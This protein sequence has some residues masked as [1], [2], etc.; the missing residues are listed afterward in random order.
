MGQSWNGATLGFIH[1]YIYYSNRI[2]WIFHYK[3]CILGH[4]H[5][6]KSPHAVLLSHGCPKDLGSAHRDS[7]PDRCWWRIILNGPSQMDADISRVRCYQWYFVIFCIF[8]DNITDVHDIIIIIDVLS[9]LHDITCIKCTSPLL[10]L[11][12]GLFC[13]LGCSNYTW[14]RRSPN[15]TNIPWASR[16]HQVPLF[17]SK[18]SK[19]K[20]GDFQ[21][22]HN[23]LNLDVQIA[24]QDLTGSN[25]S[26]FWLHL[27]RMDMPPN[28]LELAL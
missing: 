26:L 17:F 11:W 3:S 9:I 2:S 15:S 7:G 4:H 21:L 12:F 8:C 14:W 10:N 5:L 28:S 6:W 19:V 24:Q 13:H 27:A 18:L 1:L 20:T 25:R 23:L 22:F 16:C